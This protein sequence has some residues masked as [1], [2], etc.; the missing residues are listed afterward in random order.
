MMMRN[1]IFAVGKTVLLMVLI[2]VTIPK[3]EKCLHST[4]APPQSSSQRKINNRND[5]Y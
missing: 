3:D 2:N 1:T 4:T 5:K